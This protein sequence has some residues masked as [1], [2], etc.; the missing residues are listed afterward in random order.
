MPLGPVPDPL[1]ENGRW[2]FGVNIPDTTNAA[3]FSFNFS[4]SPMSNGDP[5]A[6]GEIE[7]VMQSIM[8]VLTTIPNASV[9]S[10]KN[11]TI[12]QE[13]TITE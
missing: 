1:P 12:S 10:Y 7:T 9:V 8:D 6:Q 13:F 3:W 2:D 11:I 4:L 5:A